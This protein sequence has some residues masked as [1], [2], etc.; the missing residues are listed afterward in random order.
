MN[1]IVLPTGTITWDEGQGPLIVAP[2]ELLYTGLVQGCPLQ[3]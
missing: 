1:L 2:A 3:Y